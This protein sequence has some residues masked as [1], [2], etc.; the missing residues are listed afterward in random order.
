[1]CRRHLKSANLDHSSQTQDC[2]AVNFAPETLDTVSETN[3]QSNTPA[4][5]VIHR[6]HV[7]QPI[8]D[9]DLLQRDDFTQS[10]R[11]PP[12]TP[13][14]WE[15][16]PLAHGSPL[17]NHFFSPSCEALFSSVVSLLFLS[18]N[19]RTLLERSYSN[20]KPFRWQTNLVTSGSPA[21]AQTA[22]IPSRV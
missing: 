1:M 21:D 22:A 9:E 3:K 17:I 12:D 6:Y 8:T 10:L 15:Y 20:K 14:D 13:Y 5:D 19:S 11:S 16:E 18:T 7:G 4:Q 2:S